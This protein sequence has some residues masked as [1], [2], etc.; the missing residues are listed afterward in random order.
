MYEVYD[1]RSYYGIKKADIEQAKENEEVHFVIVS[2]VDGL[3]QLKKVYPEAIVVYMYTYSM[4]DVEQLMKRESEEIT[5]SRRRARIMKMYDD[6]VRNNM[7]FDHVIIN[8][9]DLESTL[10]QLENMIRYY[11]EG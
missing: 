10:D 7:L 8:S 6:Y 1:Y 3:R 4:K 9:E 2:N 5:V 11:N